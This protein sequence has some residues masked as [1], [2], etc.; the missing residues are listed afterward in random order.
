MQLLDVDSH[1]VIVGATVVA[2]P[3]G[4]TATTDPSGSATFAALPTGLYTFTATSPKLVMAGTSVVTGAHADVTSDWISVTAAV[5]VGTTLRLER[6]DTDALN[7]V[8][9]HKSGS[10]TFTVANCKACHGD[11]KG[12][13]SADLAKPPYHALATHNSLDC[14]TCH[15]DV[16]VLNGSAATVRKQVKVT[17]CKGCHVKYPLSFP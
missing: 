14:T 2:K 11:R 1:A 5:S 17:L 9:I 3:G 7:L 16:D 8:T 4:V 10:A 13:M 6:I 15:T 12:E